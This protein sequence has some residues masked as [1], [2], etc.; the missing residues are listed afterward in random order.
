MTDRLVVSAEVSRVPGALVDVGDSL[1]SQDHGHS[2]GE[3]SPSLAAALWVSTEVLPQ[4]DRASAQQIYNAGDATGLH[5]RTIT[6]VD[7]A[8]TQNV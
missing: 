3:L 4:L 2:P 8:G 1:V 7:Q 5:Y 6:A